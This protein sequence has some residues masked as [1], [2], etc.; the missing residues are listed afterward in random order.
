MADEAE[1]PVIAVE[2]ED[3]D[4]IS[5]LEDRTKDYSTLKKIS[6]QLDDLFDLVIAGFDDKSEQSQDIDRFWDVYNC[7][8]N[9]N[10]S[11]FGTSQVYVS[12]VADAVDAL[13]TRDNNMLFP[14]NGRYATAIGSC[15]AW[16]LTP[17]YSR[18]VTL[19]RSRRRRK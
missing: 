2:E 16:G 4:E 14:V 13:T 7:V 3:A 1:N 12:A 8:L 5:D 19:A 10:Q 9:E 11:Y 18:T 17:H 6:L 15:R